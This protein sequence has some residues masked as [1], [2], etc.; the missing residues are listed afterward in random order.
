MVCRGGLGAPRRAVGGEC[1]GGGE[2]GR[3]LVA[4]KS[5]WWCQKCATEGESP[6][7]KPGEHHKHD[8]ASMKGK[9]HISRPPPPGAATRGRTAPQKVWCVPNRPRS[10]REAAPLPAVLLHS[11][12]ND[13]TTNSE[14]T[15]F[16]SVAKTSKTRHALPDRC[17]VRCEV[18]VAQRGVY[19]SHLEGQQTGHHP[20]VVKQLTQWDTIS[21]A[22]CKRTVSHC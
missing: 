17:V 1:Y 4:S 2:V 5:Y 7:D 8:K 16:V 14:T 21:V 11:R 20:G 15:M 12:A 6:R 9:T 18:G 13:R 3:S 10:H 22:R 19:S